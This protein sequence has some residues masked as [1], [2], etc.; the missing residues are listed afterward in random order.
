MGEAAEEMDAGGMQG[1]AGCSRSLWRPQPPAPSRAAVREDF[2]PTCLPFGIKLL[3]SCWTSQRGPEIRSVLQE[4][5]L[6]LPPLLLQTSFCRCE[7]NS[8]GQMCAITGQL[9]AGSIL[10]KL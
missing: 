1:L 5:S 6:A 10:F 7:F 2:S 3:I 8:P 4:S 9:W